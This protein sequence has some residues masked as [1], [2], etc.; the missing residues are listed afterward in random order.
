MLKVNCVK[1]D[2][3]TK[4][5]Y[6]NDN[7]IC[8]KKLGVTTGPCY[9]QIRCVYKGIALYVFIRPYHVLVRLNV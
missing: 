6:E 5:L 3:F 4:E 8:K 9:I 1:R 7:E 2:N